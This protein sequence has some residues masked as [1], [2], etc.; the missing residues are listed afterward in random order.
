MEVLSCFKKD[1]IPNSSPSLSRLFSSNLCLFRQEKLSQLENLKKNAM[2]GSKKS[3]LDEIFILQNMSSILADLASFLDFC[4][5]NI[6]SATLLSKYFSE[7][8]CAKMP[9]TMKN[10]Y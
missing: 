7:K 1:S 6:F 2:I 5:K 4:L 9:I 8:Y 10:I 3:W